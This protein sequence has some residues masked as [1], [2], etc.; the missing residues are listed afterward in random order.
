MLLPDGGPGEVCEGHPQAAPGRSVACR[1]FSSSSRETLILAVGV[2]PPN[3][4]PDPGRQM[5]Q[6]KRKVKEI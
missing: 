3:P 4:D 6:R 1:P 5:T 2:C